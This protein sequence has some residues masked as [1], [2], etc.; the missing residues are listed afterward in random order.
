MKEGK[1]SLKSPSK[2]RLRLNPNNLHLAE[3][4][5]TTTMMLIITLMILS[6]KLIQYKNLARKNRRE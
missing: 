3:N 6:H 1:K 2:L 5:P 4:I